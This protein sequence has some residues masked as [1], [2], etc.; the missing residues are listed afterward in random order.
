MNKPFFPAFICLIAGILAGYF[1]HLTLNMTLLLASLSIICAIFFTRTRI[2]FILISII[3]IGAA[4]FYNYTFISPLNI[5]NQASDSLAAP[6]YIKG[7]VSSPQ[8]FYKTS[9][10][11]SRSNFI[12]DAA[13]Y[14]K[15]SS[16][17]KTEGHCKVTIRDSASKYGYGSCLVLYGK[18]QPLLKNKSARAKL[19]V[20]SDSDVLALI[21]ES[22]ISA[23][24]YLKSKI[25]ALRNRINAH[26]YK[27]LPKTEADIFSAMALG[28]RSEVSDEQ[29]GLFV[30]TGTAHIL[31]IS[32]LHLSI[33]A[34]ILF[35]SLGLLRIPYNTRSA[36]V[37][38]AVIL[39]AA[40]SG[41]TTPVIRSAIMIT[42]YL[43][44]RMLNRQTDTYN[45]LSLAGIIILLFNPTQLFDAGFVLSFSCI[46]S[47]LYFYPVIAK[48]IKAD[49]IKNRSLFYLAGAF[50]ASTAVYIGTAPLIIYYFNIISP[51]TVIAN[52]FIVP[53]TM[54][55]LCAGMAF[56][57]LGFLST[58][59]A[60]VFAEALG[61]VCILM[62][63][64]VF[65]LSKAPFAYFY[66]P[67]IPPAAILGYYGL[68]VL[69]AYRKKL[70]LRNT[71][72][73]I[74]LLLAVNIFTW[75]PL[76]R[77]PGGIMKATFLSVGHGDAIFIEFPGGET[78]LIDA[79][80]AT[81]YFDA[82]KNIVMPYIWREGKNTID[83]LVITHGDNDHFGGAGAVIDRAN[84]RYLLYSGKDEGEEGY[85]AFID[86][87]KAK[88]I[89]IITAKKGSAICGFKGISM[90]VLNPSEEML[91][92]I[93]SSKNDAS[94]VIKISYKNVKILLCG[95]VLEKGIKNISAYKNALESDIVKV[96]H[97]GSKI[98][99]GVSYLFYS[100]VKPKIAII[101]SSQNYKYPI[102]AEST[103]KIL[104][105]MGIT[106]Y[107]THKDGCIVVVTDGKGYD[108]STIYCD[109]A[110]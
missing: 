60:S 70:N 46:F 62:E 32:G 71:Q 85:R 109:A 42:V 52:L 67:D 10:G 33:I 56:I 72:V 45:S 40:L 58:A 19:T 89:K 26:I 81:E 107:I 5:S 83:C 1:L 97:H 66:V 105:K 78:M 9:W 39:Y 29:R 59:F 69:A 108:V 75:G 21:G 99:E 15:E 7:K 102:P 76:I 13:Y 104:D 35:I 91:K 31:A 36:L 54:L 87:V 41:S 96:P 34:Y 61:L 12:L 2:F 30:K 95:D 88:G 79:G 16:W 57:T 22:G 65:Y 68:I 80:E 8:R 90:E 94:V 23:P 18:L 64:I 3:F 84:V 27:Y 98:D 43:L 103:L 82:G 77:L 20:T 86:R 44:G 17:I 47:L 100:L 48:V 110:Q 50:S 73:F 28:L 74:M 11:I 55:L 25:A 101:H 24:D 63:K 4:S 106:T 49:K 53:V 6:V 38:I 92:D 51:I 14:K 37:I 93:S